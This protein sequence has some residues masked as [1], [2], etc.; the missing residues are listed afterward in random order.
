[1][2]SLR[3]IRTLKGAP[4]AILILCMLDQQPHSASW[5]ERMS[6]YTDKPV[7]QA[8][9]L[10][11][12]LDFLLKTPKGWMI[13]T[14]QQLKLSTAYPQGINQNRNY[15]DSADLVVSSNTN[16]DKDLIDLTTTTRDRN[17]SDTLKDTCLE[18]GILEPKASQIAALS[19]TPEYIRAHVAAVEDL[20][21]A[22]YR[23]I[24]GWKA[25]TIKDN[26][27]RYVQGKYSDFLD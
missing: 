27:N 8:L 25:P 17:N 5:Y 3:D 22:I 21:L 6:G 18:L 2:L 20:P 23:I 12:E 16:K 24:A 10:L 13:S 11:V 14:D 19:I 15:S 26:R 4:L 9:R 1:M 7:T